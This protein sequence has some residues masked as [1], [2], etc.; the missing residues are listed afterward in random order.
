[1]KEFQT[2]LKAVEDEET[3]DDLAMAFTVDGEELVCF[4]PSDGQLAIL[5]ASVGRHSSQH[6]QIAGIINFFVEVMDERSHGYVVG[7]L[8]DREDPFGLEEV[9]AIMSWMIEEW[10]GRPT[11]SPSVSTRSQRRAGRKSTPRTSPSIS[12]GSPRTG[13]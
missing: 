11:Q 6:Q 7:R 13:S 3:D 10:T 9:E 1:M 12:S 4:P 5:I 8:L 2:A